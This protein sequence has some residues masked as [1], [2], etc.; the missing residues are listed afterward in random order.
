[1]ES[2]PS[3]KEIVPFSP[4]RFP[5]RKIRRKAF[6]SYLL[7]AHAA[8]DEFNAA[9]ERLP[10][11]HSVLS[12]L[13]ALESIDSLD[14]QKIKAS[15]KD[16]LRARALPRKEDV[17]L[18]PIIHHFQALAWSMKKSAKSPFTN[19]L[20]CSLHKKIKRGSAHKSDIGV[21]RK[22]QNWIGPHGCSIEEAYFYPPDARKVRGLMSRLL[23]FSNT[24][25]KE[26]LLQMAL[27]FGQLLIIHPFMDGNGRIARMMVPLFLY[28]KKV[29][30]FPYLFMSSY[31]K[32][33]RLR[34]FSTLFHTT[35][36]HRWEPW[37]VFFLKG[38]SIEA[39]RLKA[40]LEAI[41]RLYDDLQ[42]QN[43]SRLSVKSLHFLFQNPVFTLNSLKKAGGSKPLLSDLLRRRWIRRE[44]AGFYSFR[45]LLNI[46]SKK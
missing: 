36:E 37:I 2:F 4:R 19:A 42:M 13:L 14:S 16:V 24:A 41:A 30:S 39:K 43:I 25:S 26:P 9:F 17:K 34:Y 33:H 1:M 5:P 10:F 46:L 35:S 22:R 29:I 12:S 27:V 8:L 15:L 45:L 20:I 28:R 7:K 3:A 38:V 32:R 11:S 23:R 44:G 40:L 6:S 21:Y 31:F 18:N